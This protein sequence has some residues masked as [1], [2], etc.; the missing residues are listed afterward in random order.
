VSSVDPE[1]VPDL[2]IGFVIDS[3]EQVK[4]AKTLADTIDLLGKCNDSRKQTSP[5]G[6]A[7]NY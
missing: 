5:I 6:R 3:P 1:S 2:G 7:R 4:N